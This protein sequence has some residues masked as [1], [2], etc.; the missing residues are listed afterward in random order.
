[1][2][3]VAVNGAVLDDAEKSLIVGPG[4]ADEAAAGVAPYGVGEGAAGGGEE[5]ELAESG[6]G[7]ELD[8]L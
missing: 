6:L 5:A 3:V 7:V 4:H 8:D 1:M 2:D